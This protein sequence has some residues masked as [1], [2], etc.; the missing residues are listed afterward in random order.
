MNANKFNNSKQHIGKMVDS[1]CWSIKDNIRKTTGLTITKRYVKEK[2][3]LDAEI[4]L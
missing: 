4:G 3:K 1:S 2:L